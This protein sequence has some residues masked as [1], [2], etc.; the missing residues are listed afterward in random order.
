MVDHLTEIDPRHATDPLHRLADL[1]IRRR[2]AGRHRDGP[3]APEPTF[4]RALVPAADR[5]VANPPGLGIDAVRSFDVLVRNT[6]RRREGGQ[7]AGI[8]RVVAADDDP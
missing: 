8:A 7:M 1:V 3:R 5:L 6:F 2:R 4:L